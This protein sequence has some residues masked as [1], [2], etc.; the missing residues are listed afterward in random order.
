MVRWGVWKAYGGYERCAYT[1][2]RTHVWEID[3]AGLQMAAPV[4]AAWVGEMNSMQRGAIQRMADPRM[5]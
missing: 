1:H 5:R 2:A 3:C 4:R